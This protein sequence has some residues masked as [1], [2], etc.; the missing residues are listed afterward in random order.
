[1]GKL[2]RTQECYPDREMCKK[3]NQKSFVLLINESGDQETGKCRIL[4]NK[5]SLL[6]YQ[7][8]LEC[9]LQLHLHILKHRYNCFIGNQPEY[10]VLERHGDC[11]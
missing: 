7:E 10:I 3:Q 1:M 2:Q 5:V 6:L 9:A 11:N 8:M 4:S